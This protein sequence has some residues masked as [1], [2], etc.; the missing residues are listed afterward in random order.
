LRVVDVP[1]ELLLTARGVQKFPEHHF[2]TQRNTTTPL[3]TSSPI[4]H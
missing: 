2:K 3:I 4:Y 1:A